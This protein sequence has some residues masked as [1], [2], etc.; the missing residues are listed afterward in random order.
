MARKKIPTDAIMASRWG[1]VEVARHIGQTVLE[2]G[3]EDA[4]GVVQAE[5][6]STPSHVL[7]LSYYGS[8]VSVWINVVITG[9]SRPISAMA[10]NHVTKK[11]WYLSFVYDSNLEFLHFKELPAINGRYWMLIFSN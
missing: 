9:K 6:E 3:E 5:G 4:N 2:A 10:K 11:V 8:P 1:A 7:T